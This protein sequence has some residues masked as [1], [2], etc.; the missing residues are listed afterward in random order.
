MTTVPAYTIN[1]FTRPE[2]QLDSTGHIVLD[3]TAAA[4]A[5]AYG[6]K[7]LYLG[8]P[9]N[10]PFPPVASS[11]ST[12]IDS[13]AAGNSVLEGA[14]AGTSVNITVSATSSSGNP[15]TYSLTENSNGRFQI[16][17]SGVV[18]VANGNLI[19]YE[20]APGHAYTITV[21]ASDGILTS[22]QNFTIGVGDVNDNAPVFTSGTAAATPENVPTTTAVY[23]AHATDADGT[24][25][26]NTVT[27]SLA[28]R[29]DNDLFNIDAHN[30]AVTFKIS[31][32]F[33]APLDQ[34]GNNVYDI[35]VT[36][37]AACL[38]TMLRA[39]SPSPS[40]I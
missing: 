15:V 21:R 37:S 40:L 31:P 18:T 14:S 28:S 29:G 36:A 7:S 13:N 33:E 2:L 39:T 3:A 38:R 5:A 34:G 35:T 10:T 25:A 9:A 32:N 22:S 17:S 20:T 30:G 23:T 8:L 24:A 12:P 19:D 1:G 4:F 11:L 6:T 27:Y 16:D 26:N